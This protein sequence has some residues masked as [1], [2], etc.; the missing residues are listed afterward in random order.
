MFG[1]LG[2]LGCLLVLAVAA[3]GGYLYYTDRLPFLPHRGPAAT[4]AV[5]TWEPLTTAGSQRAQSAVA[6]LGRKS[7]PVFVNLRAAEMA[8]FLLNAMGGRLPQSVQNPEAAVI[9]D[10]V[11]LRGSVALRDF[12]GPAVLGPLSGMISERDSMRMGGEL[13]VVRPG[14]GQFRVREIKLGSLSL[15]AQLIPRLVREL[16]RGDRPEGVAAGALPLRLPPT[17]GDIRVG[18]GK[19]TLYKT[20]Q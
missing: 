4:T 3:A 15:P 20:V 2:R 7:G 9:G 16:D 10:R 13:E 18:K 19:I 17:V 1:C 12:G 11:Y 6:S 8:A 14:L 5:S